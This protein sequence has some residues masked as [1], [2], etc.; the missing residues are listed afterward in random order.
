MARE[1][2]FWL[3][4]AEPLKSRLRALVSTL[5]QSY[6]AV[7]FEPHV[8]L[9]CGASDDLGSRRTALVVANLF[10]A[11]ELTPTTIGITDEY[12][13]TLFVQFEHSAAA[14]EMYDAIGRLSAPSTYTL[15]P[16]LSL[17]YKALPLETKQRICDMLELPD[18]PYRFDRLRVIETEIPLTRGEQIRNWRDVF[19]CALGAKMDDRLPAQ[20][21][22]S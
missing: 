16:H 15:N 18:G 13:K 11:T 14:E 12:T 21:E 10:A 5:A 2:S 20:G 8:T 17:I 3:V 6:D 4:P 7:D 9:W 22:N 1:H 19:D